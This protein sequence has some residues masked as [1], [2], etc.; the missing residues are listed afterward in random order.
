M[1]EEETKA[2]PETEAAHEPAPKRATRRAAPTESAKA[3]AAGSE[4]VPAKKSEHPKAPRRPSLD[5]EEQRLLKVRETLEES[6]PKFVRTASHRYWRI[7][8]WASWRRPRG[9]QSKQRRHYGYRPKIVR[10][11]YGSPRAMRGLTPTGFKPI[12]VRTEADL[13]PLDATRDAVL[14]AR[15][16]GTK[17]RLVLEESCR[18]RGL[19]ILNPIV[20][21]RE[22]ST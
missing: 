5:P 8:R 19:H 6:R 13:A 21:E 1:A 4:K 11:G 3:P 2:T 22:E 7:G 14:I 16:V 20:K 17:R 12:L 9:Q 10:I 18:K 15:T